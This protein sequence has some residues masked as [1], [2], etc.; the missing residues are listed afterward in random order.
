M[1]A[2][3]I[4]IRIIL[5]FSISLIFLHK[6][7]SVIWDNYREWNPSTYVDIEFGNNS[8]EYTNETNGTGLTSSIRGSHYGNNAYADLVA[9]AVFE[10]MLV[11]GVIEQRYF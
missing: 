5:Q 11:V 6:N 3:I 8:S 4:A 9:P 10:K 7:A 1:D 2:F